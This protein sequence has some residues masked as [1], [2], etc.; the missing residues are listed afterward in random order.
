MARKEYF[1]QIDE[2]T[3]LRVFVLTERGQVRRFV[4]QLEVFHVNTWTPV[5]RYDTSHGFAHQDI[6]QPDGTADKIRI[7]ARDFNEAL[8]MAFADLLTNWE[9]YVERYLEKQ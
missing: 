6:L 5:C 1:R 9:R 7:V 4:V 3:R 8:D 2:R